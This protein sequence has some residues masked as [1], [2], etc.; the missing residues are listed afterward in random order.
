MS[1]TLRRRAP[2]RANGQGSPELEPGAYDETGE[3]DAV[4]PVSDV[5]PS[6][7]N[8]NGDRS[9]EPLLQCRGVDMA[10]GPVQILFDVDF[11]VNFL[12]DLA[13]MAAQPSRRPAVPLPQ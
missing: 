1:P 3:M 9:G 4:S 10:Y 8:G 12:L 6:M 11:D 5:S 7:A 13:V 2:L